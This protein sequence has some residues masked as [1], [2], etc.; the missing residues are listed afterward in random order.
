M[1]LRIPDN[2]F[3]AEAGG[4]GRLLLGSNQLGCAVAF[5]NHARIVQKN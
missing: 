4:A 5:F 2:R 3:R 1:R